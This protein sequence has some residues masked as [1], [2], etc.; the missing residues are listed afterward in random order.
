VGE[1]EKK[2]LLQIFDEEQEKKRRESG[3]EGKSNILGC[4][5]ILYDKLKC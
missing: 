2:R 4:R 5:V 1:K 3:R